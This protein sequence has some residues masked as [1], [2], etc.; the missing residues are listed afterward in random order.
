MA[1]YDL[2]F[3]DMCMLKSKKYT[4]RVVKGYDEFPLFVRVRIAGRGLYR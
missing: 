2:Y 1:L 3:A 4:I